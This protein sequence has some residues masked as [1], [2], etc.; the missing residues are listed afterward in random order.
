AEFAGNLHHRN[1]TTIYDFGVTDEGVPY[2]VQEFLTGEDLDR[3]IKTKEPQ[4]LLRKVRILIDIADGL[5]Y[6]HSQGIVHRDIKPSN[7]RILEDGTVKIMDFGIA[8]SMVS[9]STLTQTGITLGTAS[10]LAPEQ[11]RG[12]DVDPRTD[13]FS[14][15]VLAYELLTYQKP[16][17][18][19][20][21]ST[22]LYKILNEHPP[23]P[24]VLDPMIPETLSR[25][26]MRMIEKNR[27][28]RQ[29]SCAELRQELADV[30]ALLPSDSPAVGRTD[31][32]P[33]TPDMDKTLTTPTGGF[34]SAARSGGV[35]LTG[36]RSVSA[37]ARQ[38]PITPTPVGPPTVR[39]P[40]ADVRIGREETAPAGMAAEPPAGG[41]GALRIF[42]GA[43]ALVV[44]AGGAGLYLYL[45][46]PVPASGGLTDVTPVPT[47]VIE[48]TVP[49]GE[50][51]PG[52]DGSVPATSGKET[53]KF[54]ATP[55]PTAAVLVKSTP[56]SKAT[57]APVAAGT[58]E[59]RSNY[60]ST[61]TVDGRGQRPV[62]A[63]SNVRVSGLKPGAHQA[64]FHTQGYD[65]LRVKF[66]IR[67]GE[68][69]Q[70]KAE[71]AAKGK[72]RIL[73]NPEARDAVYFIDG[74]SFGPAPINEV[75]KAGA[76]K[77]DAVLDGFQPWSETVDVPEGDVK[78]LRAPLVRK[79]A[80]P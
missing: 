43:L 65:D 15:G 2:I 73:Q 42:L 37:Q 19:E 41:S 63:S 44:V 79:S 10:Y 64:V 14:L 30:V 62:G 6:A 68:T 54:D 11:I 26:V 57:A 27:D 1:V 52:T 7:V 35:P 61:L 40:L 47:A 12:E 17:M 75:V 48:G 60:Y 58:A 69:T 56:A 77:V 55:A 4:P 50:S 28:N 31:S 24:H 59:F 49:T 51:A 9:H 34:S 74:K 23:L 21:I 5:G 38:T 29:A 66:E 32:G 8:K 33:I 78:S 80:S 39:G 22:V 20:H 36:T 18:G 16:F 76:H 13:I 70:V 46:R 67:A 45:H 72:L 25:T 3:K 71:F 53:P